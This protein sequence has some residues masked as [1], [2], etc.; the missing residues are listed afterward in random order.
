MIT[1]RRRIKQATR[2]PKFI[3]KM[4]VKMTGEH[5]RLHSNYKKH[6]VVVIIIIIIIMPRLSFH[7][8]AQLVVERATEASLGLST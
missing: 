1:M 4:V 3:W 7:C 2:Q 5:Y 8:Q 6:L